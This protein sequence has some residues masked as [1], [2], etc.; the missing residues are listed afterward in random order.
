MSAKT[1]QVHDWKPITLI[2]LRH[3]FNLL[4]L[5]LTNESDFVRDK[6]ILLIKLVI[7]KNLFTLRFPFRLGRYAK[8]FVN[9]LNY[10]SS[11][12][13]YIFVCLLNMFL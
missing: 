13:Q 7:S 3:S 8:H 9:F 6:S 1:P 2:I 10:F 11:L 5:S 4:L 12:C